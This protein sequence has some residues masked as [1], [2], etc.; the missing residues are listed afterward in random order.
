MALLLLG[1]RLGV[2]AVVLALFIALIL[3]DKIGWIVQI[4]EGVF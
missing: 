2:F 3:T 1:L 4:V